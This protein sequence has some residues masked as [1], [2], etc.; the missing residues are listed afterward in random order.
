MQQTWPNQTSSS[1]LVTLT[2]YRAVAEPVREG[3]SENLTQTAHLE[4]LELVEFV[5]KDDPGL[6]SIEKNY[7]C[8]VQA[9]FG[10]QGEVCLPPDAQL[11]GAKCSVAVL[12]S[13]SNEHCHTCPKTLALLWFK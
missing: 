13:W 4:E 10:D 1:M 7:Q 12:T 2:M 8:A 3:C 5:L 6:R 11:G 9:D